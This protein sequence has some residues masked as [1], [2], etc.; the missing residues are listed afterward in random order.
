[1]IE[2]ERAQQDAVGEKKKKQKKRQSKAN[3][4]GREG[5]DVALS[6]L[7]FSTTTFV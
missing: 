6:T 5:K 3:K 7:A 4:K 2:K 1:M